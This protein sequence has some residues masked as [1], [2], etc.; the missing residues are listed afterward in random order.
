MLRIGI[1]TGGTF[2]DFVI[3]DNGVT[4]VL[5]LPSTPEAPEK[6]ILEGLAR[7]VQDRADFLIQHGSTVATNA[8]LE[9][10]GART[11]L[12]TTHGFEDII[13]IGRQNRPGLYMLSASRPEPL[14]PARLRLGVKERTLFD[15]TILVP[16]ENKNLEWLRGKVEQLSPES[17]AVVLLY[18]YVNPENETKIAQALEATRV[19]ISLSHQVL[20]EFR[21]YERTSAT[22][23]NAYLTP[24]MSRYLQ[25]LAAD[26]LVQKGR[27]TIMQ[28]NGGATSAESAALQPIR[29]L[30]SGPA[31]GVVGAF[32]RVRQAGYEKIIT[33][34]MGGTSTDVCLCNGGIQ[35]TSE[36]QVDYLP[37]PVQVI[38]IHT[39]G[40]GGGSIVWIDEGGLLRVGPQS[41][42]ADPGPVCYGKG[43]D[44]TVT[45]AHLFLGAIDPDHF[46]GGEMQLLP[47]RVL[48]ALEHLAQKLNEVSDRAWTPTEI[49]EGVIQI[50]NTQMESA[51]R[52]ISLQKG[53]DTRDFTL[54]SFGGGGGLHACDLARSLLIPRVVIPPDPGLLSAS[55]ILLAD[56][57]KDASL[58]LMRHSGEADLTERLKE[59]FGPLEERIRRQLVEE[60]FPES[61]VGI[62]KSLDMRYVGQSYEIPVP[63]S[64]GFLGGFHE[65]HQQF[66]GYSNALLPVEVVNVR[67][68]GTG[69]YSG[70]EIARSPLECQEPPAEAI[71]Q[72]RP[73]ALR[74]ESLPTRFYLRKSL[75]P[76]NRLSGPA[77]I[78]EY[79]STTL[80]APDFTAQ[81]D[82]WENLVLTGDKAEPPPPRTD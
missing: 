69:R 67:V 79:S 45:D 42:G 31:G 66:Y 53:F 70:P 74:G 80:L 29:T 12:V 54:V 75:R 49:A 40:A 33:L 51:I 6:A 52:V 50:A 11:L 78:L 24:V 13:E 37:V 48:P 32:Q 68:R 35:T 46:L 55:G 44:V 26:P 2:T 28:S 20:P 15:G 76:G 58:T 61:E 62:E 18:S 9:R 71:V 57:V 43:E 38:G 17:I 41:A 23:I 4:T 25:A 10:K 39:V 47:E 19:P 1:D 34:D 22:V 59:A 72:E 36:A 81:V 77:V 63:F 82:E 64:E 65:L 14:V 7:L 73:V 30:L 16:L 21:E 5:K 27:L 56:V 8:L 3:Q 60:G